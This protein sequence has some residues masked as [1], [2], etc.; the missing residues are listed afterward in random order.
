MN[1]LATL[2]FFNEKAETLNK[3]QR[4]ME[5]LYQRKVEFKQSPEQSGRYQLTVEGPD[6]ESIA[7]CVL[8]IRFFM[9]DNEDVSFHN[10]KAVYDK[11]A[12]SQKN[13][14]DFNQIRDELNNY[15]NSDSPLVISPQNT[16]PEIILA[17]NLN[18]NFTIPLNDALA[19]GNK[20]TNRKILDLFVY[21]HFSHGKNK[22]EEFNRL[23]LSNSAINPF[24]LFIFTG[25]LINFMKCVFAVAQ[26]NQDV[27]SEMEG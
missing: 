9:Q 13:K 17:S 5:S 14:K 4:F 12:T 16:N 2:K 21:G 27:L 1:H 18:E 24:A 20:L 26:I 6:Y 25:I 3:Y 15:L 8:T 19:S 22:K 10:M 23:F 11:L 7:A